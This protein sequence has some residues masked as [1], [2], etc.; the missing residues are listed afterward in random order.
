MLD[1]F[2]LLSHQAHWA[3]NCTEKN[4]ECQVGKR[5]RWVALTVERGFGRSPPRRSVDAILYIL[6][7]LFYIHKE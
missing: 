5:M 7:H 4:H 3:Q 1:F 6:D 2:I